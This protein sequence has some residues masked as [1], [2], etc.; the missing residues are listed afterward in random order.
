MMGDWFDSLARAFAQGGSRRTVFRAAGIGG[1][2]VASNALPQTVLGAAGGNSDCA[3][4]CQQLPPSQRGTCVSD[5]AHGQG[6]C[7]DCGP[8]GS[9]VG[10]CGSTCCPAGTVC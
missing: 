3:H 8:G 10:L 5:G 9:N 7:Y 1:A 6:L 4:F 2:V